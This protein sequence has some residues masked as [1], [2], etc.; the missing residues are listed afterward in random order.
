LKSCASVFV[1]KLPTSASGSWFCTRFQHLNGK[2]NISDPLW[3]F[4][5]NVCDS[6]SSSDVHDDNRLKAIKI[7]IFPTKEQE[8]KLKQWFGTARWTYNRCVESYQAKT[9][10]P[11]KKNLRQ[12]IINNDNFKDNNCWVKDVPYDIRDEAMNDF[13]KALKATKA[14]K[15]VKKF[16]FKFRSKKDRT[17]SITVLKKHW[18]HGFGVYSDLFHFKNMKAE[19]QL[20]EKLNYDSRLLRTRLNEHYLCIP[21]PIELRSNNQAPDF[22]NHCTI[23]LDPGVRT[24]MTGYDPDGFMLEWGKNDFGRIFRLC[25][26]YDQLQ[27]KWSQ[28]EVNHHYRYRMQV[29]GRR[30]YR[31]I[32]NLIDEV[33]KKLAE[34]LCD[35]YRQIILPIFETSNMVRRSARKIY[36]KTARAMLTWSHYRFRQ[37]LLSKSREYP[38]C[39]VVLTEEPYTSKTCG[40]CGDINAQLGGKKVFKCG[41]CN[42]VADRDMNGA[43]NILL[44]YLTLRGVSL[45]DSVGATPLL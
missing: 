38:W 2:S 18:G 9:C 27:S 24:F 1:D 16:S 36:K 21:Q 31:K 26:A 42:Y 17:Q 10:K 7:R 43:R 25:Y 41:K 6:D 11:T 39:E 5:D 34:Y 35:N 19:R 12:R 45:T 32:R 8:N 20:P 37:R 4:I 23:S 13:L 29:A 28:K 22:S 3:T 40:S 14:K 30:I 15:D 44:R 33:H